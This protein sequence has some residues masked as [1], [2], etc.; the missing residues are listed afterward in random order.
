MLSSV[1]PV[2]TGAEAASPQPTKPPASM[3]TRT[4][5][6]RRTS[7][8][9]MT[10]G[11][12]IGKLTAIG[13]MVLICTPITSGLQLLDAGLVDDALEQINFLGHAGPSGVGS[14]CAHLETGLE[15][16]LFHVRCIKHLQ[17]LFL[18]PFDGFRRRF[19]WREQNRIGCK[20]KIFVPSFLHGRNVGHVWP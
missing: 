20:Y 3:R 9:A 5:S 15:Q 7:S 13:S 18:Q 6:A 19:R 17:C 4:L 1:S 12:S 2:M 8:P 14:F 16:F 10:T 11:L